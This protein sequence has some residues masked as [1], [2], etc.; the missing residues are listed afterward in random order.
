METFISGILGDL[1]SRSISFVIDR[2]YMQQKGVEVYLLQL[3]HV[4]LRIKAIMEEAEGWHI[5]NQAMLRQLQVLRK[6]MYE[7][8][9]LLDTFTCGIQQEQG[10]TDQCGSQSF[11]YPNSVQ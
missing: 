6:M 4:L 1:F 2:C 5:T 11:A 3:R 9:Y 7:G 8:C 10:E